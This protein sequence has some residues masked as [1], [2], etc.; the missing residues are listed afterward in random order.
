MRSSEDGEDKEQ[1]LEYALLLLVYIIAKASNDTSE[2]KQ[3]LLAPGMDCA[4]FNERRVIN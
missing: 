1:Q 4:N 2:V 3:H